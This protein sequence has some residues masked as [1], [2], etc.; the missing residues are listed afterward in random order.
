MEKPTLFVNACVREASE[1][2]RLT[3]KLLTLP[4]GRAWCP[5]DR[6]QPL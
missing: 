3:E 6:R 5:V 1:T 2:I 4:G